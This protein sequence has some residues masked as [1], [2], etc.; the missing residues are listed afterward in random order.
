MSNEKATPHAVPNAQEAQKLFEQA[1]ETFEAALKSGAR[2]HEETVQRISELFSQTMSAE[3]W[4]QKSREMADQIIPSIR[5]NLDEAVTMMNTNAKASV[6]LLT[7]AFAA[8]QA[9]KLPEAQDRTRE[10][11]E[12]ALTTWRTNT[13]AMIN[14]NT[15]MLET[16]SEMAKAGPV[17]SHAS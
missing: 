4:S 14:A 3:V 17:G 7:K 12:T 10:L 2:I 6:D 5:K 15:K 11:W 1:V 9:Q 8:A 13:Q 16:W